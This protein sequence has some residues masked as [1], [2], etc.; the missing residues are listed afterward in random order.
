MKFFLLIISLSTIAFSQSNIV[1]IEKQK[2]SG[3]ITSNSSKDIPSTKEY[4]SLKYYLDTKDVLYLIGL[5]SQPLQTVGN[6]TL[7]SFPVEIKQK[8]EK[9]E[10]GAAYK[11]YLMDSLYIAPALVYINTD[12]KT[13]QY[14]NNSGTITSSITNS[15]DTDYSL[16][17]LMGYHPSKVTSLLL[18]LEL[19]NDLLGNEYGKDYS[20]YQVNFS[21]LQAISKSTLLYF[22]YNKSLKDKPSTSLHTGTQN[23][24]GFT[25]GIGFHF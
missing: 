20:T 21:I 12:S 24:N 19:N 16:Y 22:K 7:S 11:F 3:T 5:S 23:V 10:L 9:I 4:Y 13:F 25:L 14:L 18:S 1:I 2:I 6:T 8:R 17:A 15:V